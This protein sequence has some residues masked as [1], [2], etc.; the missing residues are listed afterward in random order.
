MN[1][2]ILPLESTF[3]TR[4]LGGYPCSHNKMMK[5]GK[6]LRSDRLSFATENDK[7]FL[8]E[9]YN[10]KKIIDLREDFEGNESPC[11]FKNDSRVEY[12]NIPFDLKNNLISV[13]TENDNASSEHNFV[14]SFYIE[15]LKKS[16]TNVKNVLDEILSVKDGTV[17][18]NCTEG[19]DRTGI[20]SML[21]L[22]ICGVSKKEIATNYMQSSTN[23]KYNVNN[24]FKTDNELHKIDKEILMQFKET[25]PETI[26]IVYDMIINDY[27]SFE[28]YYK[29][30][31]FSNE[32][33]EEFR[34]N[35]S[36]NV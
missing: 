15:I 10:L 12:I 28:N 25:K 30:I 8:V 14:S 32:S 36:T 16:Q 9:K 4:D 1:Y 7:N 13:F 34:E 6:C 33:I 5:W 3:N 23:L 21:L 22:G 11:G 31:G 26:E 18:F 24:K 29:E 19:K 27:G 20:V 2:V 35:F 17:L